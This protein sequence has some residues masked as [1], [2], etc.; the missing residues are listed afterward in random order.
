M[1]GGRNKQ[2]MDL[3]TY[4]ASP[5]SQEILDWKLLAFGTHTLCV[6]CGQLPRGFGDYRTASSTGREFQIFARFISRCFLSNKEMKTKIEEV[7]I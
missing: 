4:T 3:L 7:C 5:G 1:R 6:T 2:R